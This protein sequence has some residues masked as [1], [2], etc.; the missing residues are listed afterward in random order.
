MKLN[1]IIKVKIKEKKTT[2]AELAEKAGFRSQAN[3]AGLL[4]NSRKGMR[5]DNAVLLLDILDCDI[6]VRDRDDGNEW[7]VE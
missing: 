5:I 2:Q 7:K 3:I 1:D 6:I 4:N